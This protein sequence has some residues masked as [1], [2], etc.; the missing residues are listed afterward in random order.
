MPVKEDL[1]QVSEVIIMKLSAIYIAI[2][3]AGSVGVAFAAGQGQALPS[4]NV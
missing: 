2:V 4:I 1:L 3:L